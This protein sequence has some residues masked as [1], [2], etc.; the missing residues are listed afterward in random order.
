MAGKQNFGKKYHNNLRVI[1][2]VAKVGLSFGC[3]KQ[4]EN[5]EM[6]LLIM[7]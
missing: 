1:F 5:L 4:S 2:V 6:Y 3:A 7:K